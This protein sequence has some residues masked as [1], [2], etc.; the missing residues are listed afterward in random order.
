[1]EAMPKALGGG[2]GNGRI[3]KRAREQLSGPGVSPAKRTT[4]NNGNQRVVGEQ[5]GCFPFSR[6]R[7][8]RTTLTNKTTPTMVDNAL[9][10][11]NAGQRNNALVADVAD[12]DSPLA[13]SADNEKPLVTLSA[14]NGKPLV[15]GQGGNALFVGR[16][17][18][19][20]RPLSSPT[21][22]D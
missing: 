4:A 13:T 14:D 7:C 18:F 20:V 21:T 1:M 16:R 19:V 5:H 6:G 9:L 3:S 12:G 10:T 22:G 15:A 11:N 8:P 2:V 17:W